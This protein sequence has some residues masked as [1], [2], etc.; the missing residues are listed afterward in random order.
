MGPRMLLA[1]TGSK[2]LHSGPCS[3]ASISDKGTVERAAGGEWS[4][5]QAIPILVPP[6]NGAFISHRARGGL[7]LAS[8][9][10][11]IHLQSLNQRTA[12][13]P[14]LRAITEEEAPCPGLPLLL[15]LHQAW[16]G[17]SSVFLPMGRRHGLAVPQAN[18]SWQ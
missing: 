17:Q 5:A 13:K 2:K 9:S 6:G 8:H 1:P 16:W 12:T 10:R 11:S 18:S 7:A 14:Q 3:C 15:V 4:R